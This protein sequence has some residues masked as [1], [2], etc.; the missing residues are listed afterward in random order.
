MVR[1]KKR[2]T[3]LLGVLLGIALALGLVPGLAR[4][5]LV[6]AW[7]G[8]PYAGLVN[9]TTTVTFNG[10][11]WYIIAD[12]S[13]AADAGTL[14]LLAADTSFGLSKFD[15]SYSNDYDKPSAVKT[16][17]SNIVAGTAG[18][19]KPDFSNVASAIGDEGLYLLS[20]DEVSALGLSS[21]VLKMSFTGGDTHYG[22]WWLRSPGYHD[23][24]AAFV[25]GVDCYV[26]YIGIHVFKSFGV[27][28]ALQ[29]N[30]SSVIF[31][32]ESKSFSLKPHTHSL[33]YAASGATITATCTAKGCT[34]P[35][36][37]ATL[38]ISRPAKATYGDSNSADAT[39]TDEGGI[40]GEAK[41]MYQTKGAD[42]YGEATQTAPTNAGTHRASVTLAG[43]ALAGG[44]TGD[45]TAYVEYTIAKADPTAAAP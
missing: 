5:A 11:P 35:A 40:R 23:V 27:R 25:D 13:T 2:R 9:T 30:L 16:Y 4:A 42:A 28:P 19:G 6:D 14:T 32:S 43:V 22:E 20:R 18:D 36:Y 24:F 44:G 21:D 17:L 15:D 38:Q 3:A 41:V 1:G 26:D 34:D 7:E 8:N 10:K 45:V 29:L 31:E 37:S 12:G 39:V 33:A